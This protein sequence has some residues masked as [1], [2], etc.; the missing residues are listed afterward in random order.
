MH[1]ICPRCQTRLEVRDGPNTCSVCTLE[2]EVQAEAPPQIQRDVIFSGGGFRVTREFLHAGPVSYAI[3]KMASVSVGAEPPP[4]NLLV[5][6]VLFG[7]MSPAAFLFPN[8]WWMIALPVMV[9]ISLVC[10]RSYLTRSPAGIV[11]W[12][13]TAGQSQSIRCEDTLT[14]ARVKDALL[15]AM[16][17][18]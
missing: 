14:A 17:G 13:N 16:A 3:N 9:G 4:S 7:L 8:G 12:V 6:G 18:R 10:I 5:A 1:A 15:T 11:Q 2:F